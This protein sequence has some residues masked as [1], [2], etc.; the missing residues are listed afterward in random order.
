MAQH[1][2]EWPADTTAV[3]GEDMVGKRDSSKDSDPAA[4]TCTKCN[5]WLDRKAAAEQADYMMADQA[6]DVRGFAD[7]E[8]SDNDEYVDHGGWQF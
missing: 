5:E 2:M 7:D 4:T 1:Y 8:P 6:Y 3:C